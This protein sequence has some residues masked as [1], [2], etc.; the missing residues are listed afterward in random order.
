MRQN[1]IITATAILTLMTFV[2][3]GTAS[4]YD[5]S[6]VVAVPVELKYLGNVKDLPLIQ[7]DFA[8]TKDDNQ[9]S[10]S[11]TDEFGFELYSAD[12]KGEVFSKQFLLNTEDLGDAILKFE[13]TGKKSGKTVTYTVN[14]QVAARAGNAKN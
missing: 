3:A 1:K 13:I 6:T 9:F 10:I 5:S 7:L 14:P 11:I 8:G 12:V 2:F 4:A